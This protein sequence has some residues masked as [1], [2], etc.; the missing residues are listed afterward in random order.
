MKLKDTRIRIGGLMRCCLETIYQLP[1]DTDYTEGIV[2]PC[3]H[4]SSSVILEDGKW[5]WN[6]EARFKN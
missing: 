4:C 1:P 6:R 2:V 5:R 3:K